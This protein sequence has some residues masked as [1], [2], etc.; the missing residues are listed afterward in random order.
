MVDDPE[1][2]AELLIR[3]NQEVL[4]EIFRHKWIESEKAGRDIGLNDAAFD[5]M[6]KHYRD[7]CLTREYLKIFVE[8]GLIKDN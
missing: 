4:D 3:W 2:D 1:C 8:H 5:W 7:W 6:D